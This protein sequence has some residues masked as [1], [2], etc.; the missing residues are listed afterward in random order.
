MPEHAALLQTSADYVDPVAGHW[1]ADEHSERAHLGR[2]VRRALDVGQPLEPG[3]RGLLE[4]TLGADLAAVRV[5]TDGESDRLARALGADAFACGA[6]L[7]FRSG[8][9]NTGTAT[10]L[11]LLAHETAHAVQQ[12]QASRRGRPGGVRVSRSSDPD[13]RSADRAA[14]RVLQ[15]SRADLR[16]Y[17]VRVRRLRPGEPVVIQ[18]HSSWEHRL[19]GDASSADLSNIEQNAPD[20]GR[21][22]QLLT[23]LSGFLEMWR[24]SPDV[25]PDAIKAR[26][27]LIRTVKLKR[28]GLVVTYGELNTLPDYLAN[29]PSMDDLPRSILVPI[30]QAVRQEGFYNVKR[31]LG[32]DVGDI[33]FAEAVATHL[34]NGTLND[35]WESIWLNDLTANLPGTGSAR[36]GTD[37]YAALLAR[38]ACHFAPYSW[39]RWEQSYDM[40]FAKALEHYKTGDP[41]AKRQAWIHHG[42]ADHFLQDSF[43]AGHLINKTLVMQWFVEWAATQNDRWIGDWDEVKIMTAARQPGLAARGLYSPGNPGGVRDPQTAE[44]QDS[45]QKR[46]AMSGVRADALESLPQEAAYQNYLTFLNRS[47][48]QASPLAL[49]DYLNRTGLSVSSVD[50]TAPFLLY[51]DGHMLDGGDGV[52]IASDT[53]HMSQQSIQDVLDTGTTKLARVKIRDRFPTMARPEGRQDML[54]LQQWVDSM[55]GRAHKEFEGVHDWVINALNPHMGRVSMDQRA[56]VRI[57][58]TADGRQAY[59]GWTSPGWGWLVDKT[60]ATKLIMIYDNGLCFRTEDDWWLSVGTAASREGY[61]GF[62]YHQNRGTWEYDRQ[63]KR[64]KSGVN[65][66]VMS[67]RSGDSYIYCWPDYAAAE[68][69]LEEVE[70]E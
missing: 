64:L 53:A 8:A 27:P 65:G 22:T 28:S 46:M 34:S 5:H 26:Y 58:L 50:R 68:V 31:L 38:N 25:S 36:Q 51:G 13:E 17:P 57:K 37:S 6:D 47:V 52:R 16:A 62:F 60:A 9:F 7:F 40:A 12:A 24:T 43:A 66:A 44:E 15:G 49:H 10:G 63:T 29:A 61:V 14:E 59:F 3:V 1:S 32:V 54:P 33:K 67:L 2:R 18:R 41:E 69:E 19:L 55:K 35:I 48:I 42:Y 11:R 30:L 20:R 21:R 45:L 70:S 23:A 39:Y 4:R 56:T